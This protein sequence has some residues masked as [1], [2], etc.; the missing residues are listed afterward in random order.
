MGGGLI[1]LLQA[2]GS[3]PLDACCSKNLERVVPSPLK[4]E[5]SKDSI[6]WIEY[7][8]LAFP[9]LLSQCPI[10]LLQKNDQIIIFYIVGQRSV[11]L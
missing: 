5:C 7:S 4:K 8:Y 1:F 3:K 10:L 6:I 11:Q 9:R 2:S